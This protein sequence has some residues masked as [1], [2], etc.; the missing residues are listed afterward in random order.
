[1][2]VIKNNKIKIE[3][4]ERNLIMLPDL[5]YERLLSLNFRQN[6]QWNRSYS[7]IDC[8]MASAQK[9]KVP[10]GA[11][12]AIPS[13]YWSALYGSHYFDGLGPLIDVGIVESINSYSNNP[14]NSYCK[15]YR[16]NNDLFTE[17]LIK[18]RYSEEE[19]VDSN[20][21]NKHSVPLRGFLKKY[22]DSLYK[23]ID[24][25]MVGTELRIKSYLDSGEYEKKIKFDDEILERNS[26]EVDYSNIHPSAKRDVKT[27]TKKALEAAENN[28]KNLIE[29]KRKF[30]V[31][32][33]ETYLKHKRENLTFRYLTA[34]HKIKDK[35][36]Y[37]KRG[38]KERRI[39]HNLTSFPSILL[40]YITLNGEHLSSID[41]AN[42]HFVVLADLIECGYFH[43]YLDPNFPW[44][45]YK[46]KV[47]EGCYTIG[48][49]PNSILKDSNSKYE[50]PELIKPKSNFISYSDITL[51]SKLLWKMLGITDTIPV[52]LKIFIQ[53]ARLGTF[54]KFIQDKLGLPS[55]SEAKILCFELFY[56]KRRYQSHY[57][58]LIKQELP[59]LV[60]IIDAYKKDNKDKKFSIDL[61]R[62]ES[63]IFI[64]TILTT[65]IKKGFH[66]FSKHDS[67]L[68]PR[69]EKEAVEKIIKEI[70]ANEL[71]R[72]KLRAE[73]Y[74]ID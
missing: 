23:K 73:D 13:D 18:I 29:D 31:Q 54:Y 42:S 34:A 66:V 20:K 60:K 12:V 38:K 61:Q 45:A 2:E 39:H 70:L 32:N 16:L 26:I 69:S 62:R 52:D 68:C 3:K 9:K 19:V 21:F 4:G 49:D 63:E 51:P 24:I 6:S 67:I 25:D 28:N 1:M 30:I 59:N 14:S 7:M 11:F 22:M 56:S 47:Y 74:D 17:N 8:I 43:K 53:H 50:V 41:L 55:E 46:T 5:I 71:G 57:K 15:R 37:S 27:T 33:K 48:K 72:C 58:K 10:A 64:D 65:L 36:F 44:L 40:P 35:I